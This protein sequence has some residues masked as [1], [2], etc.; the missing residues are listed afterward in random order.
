MKRLVITL[1]LALSGALC[2]HAADPAPNGIT[3][4]EGYK[5]LLGQDQKPYGKDASFTQECVACHTP[6]KDNDWVFTHPVR[7][8]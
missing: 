2:A 3:L 6:V 8:P 7:L 4:P 5:D 1:T